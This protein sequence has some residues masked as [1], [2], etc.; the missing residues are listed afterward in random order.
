MAEAT[1]ITTNSQRQA[2]HK[3]GAADRP[4]A[5]RKAA[6]TRAH[7]RT[8]TAAKRTAGARKAET[9]RGLPKS[10]VERVQATAERAVLVQVGAALVARD[11]VVATVDGIVDRVGSRTKAER[12]L[13]AQRK[14]LETDLKRYER[15]GRSERTKLERDAK[16]ARTRVERE[17][18]QRRARVERLVRSNRTK[19][20]HELDEATAQAE[21]AGKDVAAQAE[22]ATARAQNLVHSGVAAGTTLAAKVTDRVA[23]V[24]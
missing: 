6:A 21:T 12:E 22:L 17:L 19:A 20:G 7:K 13:T 24:I 15:R 1:V 18:R 2:T 16:R 11:N 5:A 9:R 23:A 8:A 14:R 3:A 10:P 4:T